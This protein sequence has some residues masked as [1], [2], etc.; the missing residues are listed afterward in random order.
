MPAYPTSHSQT[1]C[2]AQRPWPPQLPMHAFGIAR[3]HVGPP[4]P[5][6]H[7]HSP[8]SVHTPWPEHEAGHSAATRSQCAPS[9]PWRHAASAHEPWPLRPSAHAGASHQSPAHPAGHAHAPATHVPLFM[10]GWIAASSAHVRRSHRAPSYP[11]SHA[12]RPSAHTPC[13]HAPE[14]PHD[15]GKAAYGVV[16]APLSRMR[17]KMNETKKARARETGYWGCMVVLA[18]T[19]RAS[20]ILSS[21]RGDLAPRALLGAPGRDGVGASVAPST[22]VELLMWFAALF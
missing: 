17:R 8:R 18:S 16:F 10:H 20:Q 4:K 3:A 21:Q 14:V 5:S 19:V 1:P 2:S 7:A 22:R 13:S 12:Q 11:A 9:K 6:S 15:D